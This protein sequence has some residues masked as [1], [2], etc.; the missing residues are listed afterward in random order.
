MDIARI[1]SELV[2][3]V[4][5]LVTGERRL[6]GGAVAVAVAYAVWLGASGVVLT[7]V[8]GLGSE[9]ASA[10]AWEA[11]GTGALA[12]GVL[13]WVVLPAAAATY[14]VDRAVTNSSGNVHQQYRVTHPFLLVA[15]FLLLF[16]IGVGAGIAIGSMSAALLAA[17]SVVGMFALVRTV[18]ASYRM[19]SF[20]RPR[21]VEAL[22]FVA[23]AVDAV[24]LLVSAATLTGRQQVVDAAASGLGG[25]FGTDVIETVLTDSVVVADLSVPTLLAVTA[26]LPVAL[27]L[28]YFVLQGGVAVVTRIRSPDVRRGDL[29]TGQRYPA[30]A[31]P[32]YGQSTAESSTDEA[33]AANESVATDGSSPAGSTSTASADGSTPS[34]TEEPAPEDTPAEVA[35][36]PEKADDDPE[37]TRVFKPPSA[38][39]FEVDETEA[40]GEEGASGEEEA[41]GY[42]CPSCNDRYGPDASFNYCPTC[43]SELEAE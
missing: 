10:A 7:S 22:L 38:D 26:S 29:R 37:K 24:A 4:H 18:P 25:K 28:L 14:L 8:L 35:D 36:A 21:F 33:V 19:F 27:S 41:T 34:S 39:M 6:L 9:P 32:T 5:L 30:F 31:Q 42:V 3:S 40:S 16:A 2:A 13:L 15:P 12:L 23:L 20:S 17:L 1:R 11:T 43:G